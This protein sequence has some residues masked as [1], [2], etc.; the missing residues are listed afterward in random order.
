[1]QCLCIFNTFVIVIGVNVSGSRYR[2]S[3]SR[4][5][6]KNIKYVFKHPAVIFLWIH[7]NVLTA[8]L[9]IRSY[10]TLKSNSR[11]VLGSNKLYRI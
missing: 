3:S 8:P 6:D 7:N 10:T 2:V 11:S 5:R 4:P 9:L 1:M